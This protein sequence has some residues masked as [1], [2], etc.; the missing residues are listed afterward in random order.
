[1][2]TPAKPMLLTLSMA[3]CLPLAAARSADT[4]T[5]Y[6]TNLAS[7]PVTVIVQTA[8]VENGQV[9]VEKTSEKDIAPGAKNVAIS[10][11][12]KEIY[13]IA[14][15]LDTKQ[16]PNRTFTKG[17]RIN[18]NRYFSIDDDMSVDMQNDPFR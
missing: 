15:T 7:K 11:P 13:K 8:T 14:F 5:K 12:G 1:M 4:V 17:Q 6:F 10:I 2:T 16:H 18:S 9:K 3:C